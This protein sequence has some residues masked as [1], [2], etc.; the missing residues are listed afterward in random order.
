MKKLISGC[1]LLLSCFFAYAQHTE[2]RTGI[3]DTTYSSKSDYKQNIKNYPFIKLVSDEPQANVTE[4]RNLVYAKLGERELHIDAFIPKNAN[5][6]IPAILIIHG[7]GW[8][9]GDRSQHIPL[10][11]HLA[12]RGIA[13]FTVEYRLSTE[14]F[15][16]NAVYDLKSAIRW[17]RSNAARFHID[18]NKINV[19]GFSAGGELAAFLGVTNGIPKFE[20]PEGNYNSSSKVN[21]VIDIDG[22]L[23]FVSPDAWETQNQQTIGASADW[24]GYPRT[25]RL[26]LWTQASPFTYTDRNTAPFLFLNSAV[27]RMHAG[28]DDFKKVMD[29]KHVYVEI[30]NFPDTPHSFCLYEPWFNSVVDDIIAFVQKICTN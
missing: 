3:R 12:T 18:T 9:S 10:A 6:N 29:Q 1:V 26:D 16:P 17:L 24:I 8:R 14:A 28:R 13:C 4:E 22:T 30:K 23:S 2:W 25:E 11:Q 27:E 20:G 19:L 7:G 5:T 21:A 15:Y